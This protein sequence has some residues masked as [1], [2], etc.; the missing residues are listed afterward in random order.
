MISFDPPNRRRG[1]SEQG[2]DMLGAGRRSSQIAKHIEHILLSKHSPPGLNDSHTH[3]LCQGKGAIGVI[4]DVGVPEMQIGSVVSVFCRAE[5]QSL[6]LQA[7]AKQAPSKP[8]PN[9]IR[10]I[11]GTRGSPARTLRARFWCTSPKLIS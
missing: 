9:R 10:P 8:H 1:L 2:A 3:R 5:R 6:R 4:D 7:L 11:K